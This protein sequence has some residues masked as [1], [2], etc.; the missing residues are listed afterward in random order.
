MSK[1]SVGSPPGV[2]SVL[3]QPV[4][5][6]YRNCHNYRDCNNYRNYHNC[7]PRWSETARS[8]NVARLVDRLDALLTIVSYCKGTGP[9]PPAVQERN[10]PEGNP[11]P[12]PAGQ[13]RN[14]PEGQPDRSQKA[15]LTGPYRKSPETCCAPVQDSQ[16]VA[17]RYFRVLSTAPRSIN[18]PAVTRPDVGSQHPSTL[19]R[20]THACPPTRSPTR[21][22]LPSHQNPNPLPP[23]PQP[24]PTRTLTPSH[25]APPGPDHN[26]T[27]CRASSAGGCS[28]GFWLTLCMP[29]SLL[30]PTYHAAAPHHGAPSPPCCSRLAWPP[31]FEC[32]VLYRQGPSCRN[33]WRLLHPDGGVNSLVEAMSSTFDDFYRTRAK[34]AFLKCDLRYIPEENESADPELMA[35]IANQNQTVF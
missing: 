2:R 16:A 30:V 31:F 18:A 14:S 4:C 12:P 15:T 8:A 24:P 25:P 17:S 34:F 11:D 7:R 5:H 9:P 33:P 20:N 22:P 32:R 29:P 23:E 28:S 27:S 13:E 3:L 35:A 10:D 19:L 1:G 6:S 26:I 21:T